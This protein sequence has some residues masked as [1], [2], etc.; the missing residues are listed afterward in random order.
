MK[1]YISILVCLFFLFFSLLEIYNFSALYKDQVEHK[2]M[3]AK[4]VSNDYCFSLIDKSSELTSAID[5]FVYCAITS[6]VALFFLIY[7]KY[8]NS[9]KST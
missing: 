2:A 5:F 4:N 9:K 3:M 1:A 8:N 7:K 6:F